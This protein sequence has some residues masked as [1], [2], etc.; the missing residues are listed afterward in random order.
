MLLPVACIGGNALVNAFAIGMGWPMLLYPVLLYVH[1][2]LG[3]PY[4]ALSVFASS[5]VCVFYALHG[6]GPFS[7]PSGSL[8]L[9]ADAAMQLYVGVQAVV[10]VLLVVLIR[11]RPMASHWHSAMGRRYRFMGKDPLTGATN[12][13]GFEKA[14]A[15]AWHAAATS[16][17]PLSMLMIHL[18]DFEQFKVRYGR[19][20]GEACLLRVA[21]VLRSAL[22]ETHVLGRMGEGKF[23]V[24][25]PACSVQACF[26]LADRLRREVA[27]TAVDHEHSNWGLVTISVGCATMLPATGGECHSLSAEANGALHQ[28]QR[29]GRNRL[30]SPLTISPPLFAV[31]QPAETTH[32]YDCAQAPQEPAPTDWNEIQKLTWNLHSALG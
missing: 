13:R 4:A 1:W 3:F 30:V 5:V 15:K 16:Q 20:D 32:G 18:D 8:V 27:C 23:A 25:L 12:E 29:Q 21:G 31:S 22:E 6:L 17:I 14:L 9:A 7:H 2:K 24:L 10:L 19:L 11:C 28:A 26:H